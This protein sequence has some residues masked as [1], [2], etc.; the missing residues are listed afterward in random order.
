[1]NLHSGQRFP[2]TVTGDPGRDPFLEFQQPLP[3]LAVP[4]RPVRPYRPGHRADQL[5]SQRFDAATA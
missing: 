4:V 2:I 5:I 1:M 3:R